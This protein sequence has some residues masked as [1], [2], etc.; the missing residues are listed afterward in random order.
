MTSVL[1]R[2]RIAERGAAV[3]LQQAVFAERPGWGTQRDGAGLGGGSVDGVAA[4]L[5]EARP[6][7]ETLLETLCER[8]PATFPVQARA[9]LARVA[10]RSTPRMPPAPPLES[11]DGERD[12][13]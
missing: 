3:V 1:V 13:G 8:F 9:L 2:Q 6:L 10:R 7:L 11:E 12:D 5:R 4:R